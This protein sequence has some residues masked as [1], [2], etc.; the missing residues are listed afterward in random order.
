MPE[1][2]DEQKP[3]FFTLFQVVGEIRGEVKG[4]NSRLDRLNG[5]LSNHEDRINKN[6]DGISNI[7]GRA[8]GAG[9]IA[10]FIGGVITVIIAIVT[11]FRKL[12]L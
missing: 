12:N 9:A 10:G 7:R 6:E 4:I 1:N 3:N 5:H 8:T 11:F 2:K